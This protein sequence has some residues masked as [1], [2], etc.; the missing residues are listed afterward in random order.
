MRGR[1]TFKSWGER[2]T[3]GHLHLLI[4][5]TQ[6]ESKFS[7]T[8]VSGGSFKIWSTA[9]AGVRLSPLA[10]ARRWG[11]CLL[12]WHIS[13][14][15]PRSLRKVFLGRRS[16]KR[17]LKQIYTS[18]DRERFCNSN[19]SKVNTPRKGKLEPSVRKKSDSSL[20]EVIFISGPL[21]TLILTQE[22]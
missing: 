7:F 18:K 16:S 2:E 3:S 12:W 17:L 10:E 20:V 11:C 21:I 13:N 5:F 22:L 4:V 1:R 9:Q 14:N 19:F 15:G 6:R 8:F